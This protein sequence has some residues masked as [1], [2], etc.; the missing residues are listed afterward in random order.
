MPKTNQTHVK[1]TPIPL[2]PLEE[3]RRIIAKS[4]D[5]FRYID[6]I[7]NIMERSKI[8]VEI[9]ENAIIAKAYR[10]ELASQD[11]DDEPASTLLD[12]INAKRQ[13]NAHKS[14]TNLNEFM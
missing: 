5:L 7:R 6:K 3:Q 1:N 10:G 14:T 13:L 9:I 8:K 12:R 2:A 4:A 11:P